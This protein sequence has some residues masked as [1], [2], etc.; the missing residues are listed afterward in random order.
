MQGE[1]FDNNNEEAFNIS[2][3]LERQIEVDEQGMAC[4]IEQL[5]AIV[6]DLTMVIH[7]L[8]SLS[9]VKE[10]LDP[11][12]YDDVVTLAASAHS[13][14]CPETGEEEHEETVEVSSA[15]TE[16]LFDSLL[17]PLHEASVAWLA[18]IRNRDPHYN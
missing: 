12:V 4:N 11:E 14:V 9:H 2:N 3:Y 1:W 13:L 15:T 16:E 6:H 8:A 7:K 17:E 10:D 5:R 18:R